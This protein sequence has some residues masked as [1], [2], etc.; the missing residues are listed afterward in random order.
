MNREQRE[1]ARKYEVYSTKTGEVIDF[2]EAVAE[3]IKV[4]DTKAENGFEL[5]YLKVLVDFVEAADNPRAKVLGYF[6]RNKVSVTNQIS[7]TYAEVAKDLGVSIK[8]VTAV[9]G[10]LQKS[11]L[12]KK[13]RNGQY[14]LNPDIAMRGGKARWAAKTVWDK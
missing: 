12:L 14:L 5:T 7:T 13:V 11:G 3:Y 6:L 4:T 8:V 2:E 10:S 1:V 9:I